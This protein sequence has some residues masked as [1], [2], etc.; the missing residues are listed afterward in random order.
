[1]PPGPPLAP[2]YFIAYILPCFFHGLIAAAMPL[3]LPLAAQKHYR[4]LCVHSYSSS[5]IND[6]K[7]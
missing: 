4:S 6:F 3:A 1:M 5:F 7:T 2:K